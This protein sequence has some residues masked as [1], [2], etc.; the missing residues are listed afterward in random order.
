MTFLWNA[1][2]RPEPWLDDGPP[3]P[4]CP[5]TDVKEDSFCYHPMLWAY[6]SGVTGGTTATTFGPRANCTRAQVVTFLY[7]SAALNALEE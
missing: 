4:D 1:A 5:F 3:A 7:K 6:Y 2:G